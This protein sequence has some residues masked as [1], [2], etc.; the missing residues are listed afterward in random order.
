[1][2]N[3]KKNID[4]FLEGQIFLF[5]RVFPVFFGKI[6][7]KSRSYGRFFFTVPSGEQGGACAGAVTKYI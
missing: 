1:M 4:F 2:I 3:E 5:E 6:P 7:Y